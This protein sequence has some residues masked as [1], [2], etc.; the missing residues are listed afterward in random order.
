[1]ADSLEARIAEQVVRAL[2]GGDPV[3]VAR[4]LGNSGKPRFQRRDDLTD[5]A[6]FELELRDVARQ[7]APRG[8]NIDRCHRIPSR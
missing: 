8:G 2:D 3:L 6:A 1:M 7:I 5:G 4:P